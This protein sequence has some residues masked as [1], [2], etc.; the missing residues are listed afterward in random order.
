MIDINKKYRL[1]NGWEARI[2]ATDG[3]GGSI[4]GAYKHPEHEWVA[5][6]WYPGGKWRYTLEDNSYDLVEAK[7]RIKT[8]VWL[9][10]EPNGKVVT[11]YPSREMANFNAHRSNFGLHKSRIACVRVEIDVEEGHGL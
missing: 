3:A 1:R 6:T 7:P 8:T 2:Y 11:A 5:V 4:H 9:N 10:I